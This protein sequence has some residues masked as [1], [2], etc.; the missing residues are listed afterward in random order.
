MYVQ[1]F[2]KVFFSE[3]FSD[4]I[5]PSAHPVKSPLNPTPSQVSYSFQYRR[6]AHMCIFKHQKTKRKSRF[7]QPFLISKSGLL[8]LPHFGGRFV[9]RLFTVQP[10][11]FPD[12][13]SC[14]LIAAVVPRIVRMALYL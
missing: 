8:L 12:G 9:L 10:A 7:K 3:M 2:V 5:L 14:Q 4:S 11:V 6:K 13:R 1:L